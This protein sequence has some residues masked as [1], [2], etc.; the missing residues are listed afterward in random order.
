MCRR[1]VIFQ[2]SI[3]REKKLK[4]VTHSDIWI[5]AVNLTYLMRSCDSS[6]V[7][8]MKPDTGEI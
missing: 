5:T 6:N 4:Q 8:D 2:Y 7:R 1:V 3:F